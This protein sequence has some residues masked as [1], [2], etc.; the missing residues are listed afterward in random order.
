[1]TTKSPTLDR[2]SAKFWAV[3]GAA[4]ANASAKPSAELRTIVVLLHLR[5]RPR[6]L[7]VHRF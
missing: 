2:E 3:V 5:G 4:I 1:M 6:G 7:D